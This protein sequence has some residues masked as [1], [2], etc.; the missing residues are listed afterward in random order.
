MGGKGKVLF[1]LFVTFTLSICIIII[2]NELE[3]RC[4]LLNSNLVFC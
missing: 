3:Q 1:L 2:I 4:F